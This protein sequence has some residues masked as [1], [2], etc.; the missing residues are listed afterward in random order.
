M[1]ANKTPLVTIILPVFN[2]EKTLSVCIDSLLA[3]TYKNIELMI[4]DDGS[5]DRSWDIV[6]S[7]SDTRLNKIQLENN[8]GLV[9]VL[10]LAL[11]Q[12]SGRYIARMDADD[13]ALPQRIEKQV[14]FLEANPDYGACGTAIY[15]FNNDH[16]S[17]MRYPVE[18]E[19]I[20]THLTLFERNIC[21][22]TVVMRASVIR[23]NNIHYR[24]EFIHA[25]DYMLWV[26]ISRYSKLYNLK[27]AYLKY[28]RHESQVSSKYYPEQIETSKEI[29]SILMH[30]FFGRDLSEAELS[31]LFSFLIHRVDMK[32]QNAHIEQMKSCRDMLLNFNNSHAIFLP[33]IFRKVVNFKYL[34]CCFYYRFPKREK[35]KAFFRLIFSDPAFGLK[36]LAELS[37]L[38]AYYRLRKRL[39][40]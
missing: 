5:T 38:F 10:N 35:I 17:Y 20:M 11:S 7:Y 3:Q 26:D 32:G 28:Y 24:E 4:L 29:I 9:S 33:R 15:N 6:D 14:M 22:P 40:A 23:N 36:Y 25:E 13:I 16:S 1:T 37:Y 39:D 27:T 21:H 30:D 34:R 8:Q 19:E 18:H 31:L 2:A 12:A